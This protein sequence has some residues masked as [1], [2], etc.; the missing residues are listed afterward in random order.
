M[1]PSSCPPTPHKH[2]YLWSDHCIKEVRCSQW[3][4]QIILWMSL[5]LLV[6]VA[7]ISMLLFVLK[8][9]L[10]FVVCRNDLGRLHLVYLHRYVSSWFCYL[11]WIH[12]HSAGCCFW[13]WEIRSYLHGIW[14]RFSNCDLDLIVTGILS[15]FLAHNIL[16]LGGSFFT[17]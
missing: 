7:F 2:L 6:F 17:L 13:S 9:C 8:G 3:Q 16:S 5:F 14:R 15:N 11:G 1:N 12:I 10:L 4:F